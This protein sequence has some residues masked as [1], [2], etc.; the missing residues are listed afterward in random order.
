MTR[1]TRYPAETAHAFVTTSRLG[2]KYLLARVKVSLLS[3]TSD[4]FFF[5]FIFFL[6]S[7]RFRFLFSFLF[8]ILIHLG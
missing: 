8:I 6:F 1:L 3:V 4:L 2:M 7:F 5:S